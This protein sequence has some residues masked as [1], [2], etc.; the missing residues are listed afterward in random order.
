MFLGKFQTP[1]NHPIKL[2]SRFQGNDPSHLG[3][4]TTA[5]FSFF[6]NKKFFFNFRKFM[7]YLVYSVWVIY[8][9]LDIIKFSK[10]VLV[11]LRSLIFRLEN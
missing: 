9:Y 8:D 4:L 11:I 5:A 3:S 6:I 1:L 10:L 7:D 2:S